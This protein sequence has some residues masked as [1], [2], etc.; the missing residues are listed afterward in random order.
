MCAF[1]VRPVPEPHPSMC[2]LVQQS[3]SRVRIWQF[4]RAEVPEARRVFRYQS[5]SAEMKGIIRVS[6]ELYAI[7]G[8]PC[9][10]MFKRPRVAYFNRLR[11]C[12]PF[13]G[14]VVNPVYSNFSGQ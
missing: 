8:K 1:G 7:M 6:K 2:A 14:L 10:T 3:K 9:Y 4:V 11:E 5:S 13:S 12:L